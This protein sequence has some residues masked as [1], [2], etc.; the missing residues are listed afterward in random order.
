ML[1]AY[2]NRTSATSDPMLHHFS[3]TT[4]IFRR[5][6]NLNRTFEITSSVFNFKL[7][8]NLQFSNQSQSLALRDDQRQSIF[9]MDLVFQ[10]FD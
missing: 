4:A 5:F 9:K 2:E 10:F 8:S 3:R 7:A 1:E 6:Q